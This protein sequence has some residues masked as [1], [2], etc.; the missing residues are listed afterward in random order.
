M[1]RGYLYPAGKGRKMDETV[2]KEIEHK[3]AKKIIDAVL[4]YAPDPGTEKTAE[5][6]SLVR[7]V[8]SVINNDAEYRHCI[9]HAVAEKIIDEVLDHAEELNFAWHYGEESLLV[10]DVVN[11]VNNAAGTSYK[12]YGKGFLGYK[13]WDPV[14]GDGK[15]SLCSEFFARHPK[16]EHRMHCAGGKDASKCSRF[17]DSL[18]TYFK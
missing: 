16:S 17:S 9:E 13:K 15:C 12:R 4:D 8:A 18:E 1:N 10:G 7:Y 2:I 3:L 6:E 14:S 5:N 11:L